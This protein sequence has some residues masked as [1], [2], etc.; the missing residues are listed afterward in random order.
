MEL[1]IIAVLIV[2]NG[3]FVAAEFAL[4]RVRRTRLEQLADEGHRGAR[5]VQR[6]VAHATAITAVVSGDLLLTGSPAGNGMHHR[7]FLGPG[8]V[9]ESEI[10]GLGAQ[11]NRCV[12]AS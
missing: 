3:F 6:L 8:D 7:R 9:M 2:L 10:T 4:V 12:A 1:V 5:R 11:R